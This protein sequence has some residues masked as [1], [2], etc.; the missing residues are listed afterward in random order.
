MLVVSPDG[1]QGLSDVNPSNSSLG[2]AK[3]TPHSGLEPISSGT[4]QHFVDAENMEGMDTDANVELILS[5]VLHHVLKIS[6][7]VNMANNIRI[8][9]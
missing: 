1:H 6:N 9:D 7:K 8:K 5:S 2:L 3:S 4:T